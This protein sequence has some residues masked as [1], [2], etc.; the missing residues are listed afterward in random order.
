MI[1]QNDKT[2]QNVTEKCKT[3]LTQN[4]GKPTYTVYILKFEHPRNWHK[5]L[6]ELANAYCNVLIYYKLKGQERKI[7]NLWKLHDLGHQYFDWLKYRN[8]FVDRLSLK[9]KNVLLLCLI[10]QRFELSNFQTFFRKIK[11]LHVCQA[12][13]CFSHTIIKSESEKSIRI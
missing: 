10:N 2:K 8:G 1:K 11:K 13:Y 5:L 12:M 4:T 6:F 9:G 3:T 7:W